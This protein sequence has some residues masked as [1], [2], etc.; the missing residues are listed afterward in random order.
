MTYKASID[1]E[2]TKEYR[3]IIA[4]EQLTAR[5]IDRIMETGSQ[6]KI[7]TYE[8]SIE[9]LVD[10][11]APEHEELVLEYIKKHD[12]KY[13]ISNE[14]KQKYRELFRYIKSILTKG[15]IVW[16]RSSYEMGKE[17]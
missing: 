13:D 5:Q 9:M 7:E 3:G 11:L 10:L 16:K 17:E 15:N 12:I 8:E 2:V 1:R 4:I 6:K 14:G